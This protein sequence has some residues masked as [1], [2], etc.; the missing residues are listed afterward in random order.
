LLPSALSRLPEADDCAFPCAGAGLLVNALWP[1]SVVPESELL[2][3]PPW[4]VVVEVVEFVR[5]VS[6]D[7]AAAPELAAST[8]PEPLMVLPL[9]GL[10]ECGRMEVVSAVLEV[11]EL[12]SRVAALP[13]RSLLLLLQPT[14]AANSA[15]A[16]K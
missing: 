4:F 16:N 11:A 12:V 1:L 14:S 13:I 2:N 10:V 5:G 3:A 7:P 8:D 15:V 6:S 9:S